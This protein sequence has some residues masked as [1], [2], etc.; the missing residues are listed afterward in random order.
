MWVLVISVAINS[1]LQW[2]KPLAQGQEFV[3]SV[4]SFRYMCLS[5]GAFQ[6]LTVVWCTS[7]HIFPLWILPVPAM[8]LA[9]WQRQ[10][11]EFQYPIVIP[12]ICNTMIIAL[13]V[14]IPYVAI[15]MGASVRG[16]RSLCL[17]GCQKIT[18][19]MTKMLSSA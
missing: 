7:P 6:L 12:T 17:F 8:V 2:L 18:A 3:M 11:E 15:S 16:E 10:R 19:S 4:P 14:W 13:L 9:E 5:Q 1:V